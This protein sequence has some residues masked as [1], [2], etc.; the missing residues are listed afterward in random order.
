[1]STS[2]LKTWFAVDDP[3][4]GSSPALRYVN[5]THT[6]A[7]LI[8]VIASRGIRAGG[9]EPWVYLKTGDGKPCKGTAAE[10]HCF[11]VAGTPKPDANG[12]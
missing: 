12:D 9:A 4:T 6:Y 11:T 2:A 3:E 10:G 5:D 8:S 1:M 7:S